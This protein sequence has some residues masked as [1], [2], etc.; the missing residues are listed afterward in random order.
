MDSNL[1]SKKEGQSL[2]LILL[3][4]AKLTCFF[5]ILNPVTKK[6]QA[7]SGMLQQHQQF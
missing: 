4:L 6:V 1:S 7:T 3:S 2:N 5:C